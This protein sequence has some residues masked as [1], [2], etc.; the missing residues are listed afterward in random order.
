[1]PRRII[2]RRP[3]IGTMT[4][5]VAPVR[6]VRTPIRPPIGSRTLRGRRRGEPLSRVV[7]PRPTKPPGEPL[8]RRLNPRPV[9]PTGLSRVQSPRPART[10]RRRKV[11]LPGVPRR[12]RAK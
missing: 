7:S 5:G 3:G 11:V 10:I 9:A 8:R 4:T 12:R 1:M 6:P 2:K